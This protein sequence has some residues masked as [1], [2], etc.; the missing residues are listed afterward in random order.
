M[1]MPHPDT[2]SSKAETA[3]DDGFQSLYPSKAVG[4]EI[5][6]ALLDGARHIEVK[7][8]DLTYSFATPGFPAAATPLLGHCR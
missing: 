4:T 2:W 5:I 3:T 8:G 6:D 7:A 1:W